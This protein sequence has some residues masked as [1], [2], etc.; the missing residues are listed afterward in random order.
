MTQAGNALRLTDMLKTIKRVWLLLLVATLVYLLDRSWGGIPAAGKLFSPFHGFLQHVEDPLQYREGILELPD[1][2]GRV[3]VHYDDNGVPHIFAENDHDLYLAQGYVI[4][5][6]R[7]W[8]MDFYT[9]AAAGRLAEIVGD[10]AL[11]LDRY[12]RRLGMARTARKIVEYLR[13]TDSLSYAIL[14]AYATGVN[15]YI[16]SLDSRQIPLEYKILS[17]VPEAWSPYKSIL[18]LMNMRHDLSSGTNDFRMS[19][20]LAQIGAAAMSDLF[21]DYPSFESPIIPAGTVW[22]FDPVNIPAIPDTV[23]RMLAQSDTVG[24]RLAAQVDFPEPR[25]EIGSNNWAVSGTRSATGLPLLANDPH[26][27]LTLPSIWYQMQLHAPG[28]NVY[29]VALPGTPAIIIGFNKDIAWGVTNVGSDVMDF[30]RI[31]FR[32]A[33]KREYWHDGVW[34]PVDARVEIFRRKGLDDFVDT[35]YYTHHGPIVYHEDSGGNHVDL[36]IGH[37]MR[38]VGNESQSSD[39]LT[40]HYLNRAEDYEDYRMALSFFAAPAQNFVFADNANNIAITSNGR[41]PVKWHGQGR[42]LMDGTLASN[43]WQGWIPFEHNPHVLNPERGFVSSANQFPADT[44]YPYYL[45]WDFAPSSRALR[46]NERLEELNSATVEDFVSLLHDNYNMDA[47]RILPSLLEDLA[48]DASIASS[49]AYR[50]LKDWD[51]LNDAG[52]VAAS[53]FERWIPRLSAGIWK[54]E[55][56]SGSSIIYPTLDRTYRLLLEEPDSGWFD[57][58]MTPE[59]FETKGDIVRYTFLETLIALEEK[60]GPLSDPDETNTEWQWARVKNTT[61]SHLVPNFASFG[62]SGIENGG[63]V[64]IVNATSHSHGPSW[65]MIVQLDRDWPQAWGLFPGGQ[66]GN[67]GS[68][69][70]DN[71]IDLWAAGSLNELL[72]LRNPED[73]NVRLKSTLLLN[74][75]KKRLKR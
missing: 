36:P 65:R 45:G 22:D 26:L 43:D 39:L 42:F 59:D 54:D 46:I 64:R 48:A 47:R 31:R 3:S 18:M 68:P 63:G 38:W 40:F 19:N 17:Y 41:L 75:S 58:R 55:F 11:D 27:T 5:K 2:N 21:P 62:R 6:D 24:E 66:S 52:S 71:M 73:S 35:V 53:I 1:L 8:Q 25:P 74:P 30:Y 44:T 50:A 57:D 37:A 16:A 7:L 12:H 67:P 61:I 34:K 10:A 56:S 4:A 70:Y 33:E 15:A 69:Y 49:S 72:F 60:R 29:G 14:E 51:Y 32:D 28:V 23:L 13:E 9:L 20:V